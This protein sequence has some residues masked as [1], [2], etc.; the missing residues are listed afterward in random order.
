[1]FVCIWCIACKRLVCPPFHTHTLICTCT[2]NS[3]TEKYSIPIYVVPV[4]SRS[5]STYACYN[6]VCYVFLKCI[7]YYIPGKVYAL[8]YARI[9]YVY[10][11]RVMLTYT[12]LVITYS[13]V[14]TTVHSTC[15]QCS[16]VY[17]TTGVHSFP[18][19]SRSQT[20]HTRNKANRNSKILPV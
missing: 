14:S 3:N 6:T 11:G 9:L 7:Y 1:M 12:N 5:V 16:W 19:N 18:I 13:G 2:T 20:V 17:T 15:V 8:I 4:Y 10:R